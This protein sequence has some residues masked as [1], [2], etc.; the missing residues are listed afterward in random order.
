MN[1]IVNILPTNSRQISNKFVAIEARIVSYLIACNGDTPISHYDETNHS[2]MVCFSG[3]NIAT[4]S[5]P[6]EV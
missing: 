4:S 5:V 3:T 1:I 2:G 6:V